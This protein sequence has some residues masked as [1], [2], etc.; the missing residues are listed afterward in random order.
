MWEWDG[1]V[2]WLAI[3]LIAALLFG[4]GLQYGRW[5]E[6]KAA[7]DLLPR[8][9][10]GDAAAAGAGG[11]K[12]LVPGEA[13]MAAV[14]GK[15]DG[16]AGGAA[17]APM[18]T[19]QVHV[20]GAVARPGVYELPAGARV[21][22]AVSLAGLLPEADANA[23]NLAAPLSDGQQVIVPRQGEAA[24]P[25]GG[26]GL[27][28]VP[29][30][31]GGIGAGSAAAGA[32]AAGA[33]AG[34]KVNINTAPLAELDTLPGIGPTLAQRIIDYRQEKGPFRSIED[35]QN[36]SGIGTKKFADLKDLVTVY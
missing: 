15:S 30:T 9:V 27:Q 12:I 3:G 14:D 7:D 25:A 19:I 31:T 16:G 33:P 5:Q 34:G 29:G 36:V 20:A 17:A 6:R 10:T 1:R 22:E 32:A 18:A 8:V 21:N 35:L 2:R 26:G 4:L 23:L 13:G 11:G 28:V 24:G